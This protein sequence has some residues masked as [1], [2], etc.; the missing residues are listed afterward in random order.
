[1]PGPRFRSLSAVANL[2]GTTGFSHK[3]AEGLMKWSRRRLFRDARRYDKVHAIRTEFRDA[4]SKLPAGD[5]LVL[6][7]F[8][9][10]QKAMAF[11]AG[12]SMGLTA[13]LVSNA[14]TPSEQTP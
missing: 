11:D 10:I 6:G 14:N 13:A 5:R 4:V 7:K 12:L 2:L 1:M 9:A 8:I 3:T